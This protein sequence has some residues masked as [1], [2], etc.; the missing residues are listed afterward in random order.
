MGEF[1]SSL[2]CEGLKSYPVSRSPCN[3]RY[4]Y[5]LVK[6][7]PTVCHMLLASGVGGVAAHNKTHSIYIWQHPP[8]AGPS[9]RNN[10]HRVYLDFYRS[11]VKEYLERKGINRIRVWSNMGNVERCSPR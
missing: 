6:V 11:R 1:N 9:S 5:R 8:G 2:E 3:I 7:D 10:N 4:I